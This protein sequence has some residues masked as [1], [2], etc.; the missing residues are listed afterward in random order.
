LAL[1]FGVVLGNRQATIIYHFQDGAYHKVIDLSEN[2]RK[3]KQK[4]SEF[5]EISVDKDMGVC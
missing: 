4:K 2:S 1:Y 5:K 3:I